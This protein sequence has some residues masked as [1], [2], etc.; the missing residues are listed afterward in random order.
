V[1]DFLKFKVVQIKEDVLESLLL[2]NENIFQKNG[3]TLLNSDRISRIWD[4]M[5]TKLG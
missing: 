2:F 4:E 5:R 1:V 3:S